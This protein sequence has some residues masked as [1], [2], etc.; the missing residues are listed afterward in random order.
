M[1]EKIEHLG[2]AGAGTTGNDQDIDEMGIF[3]FEIFDTT[4]KAGEVVF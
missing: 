2:F 3:G 1:G 4:V